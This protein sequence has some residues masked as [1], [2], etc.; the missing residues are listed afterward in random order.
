M[1]ERSRFD[2]EGFLGLNPIVSM[3]AWPAPVHDLLAVA[4]EINRTSMAII[5]VIPVTDGDARAIVAA[6][7][8]SRATTT[9]QS[10]LMLLTRGLEVDGLTLGRSLFETA[11]V[12]RGLSDDPGLVDTLTADYARHHIKIERE[13]KAQL[14][15]GGNTGDGGLGRRLMEAAAAQAQSQTGY[16][17]TSPSL[18]LQVLANKCGLEWLY[19]VVYRGLSGE[20][21]HPHFDSL[22]KHVNFDADGK[23]V[24]T[25]FR[26]LYGSLAN[27]ALIAILC[28]LVALDGA[29]RTFPDTALRGQLDAWLARVMGHVEKAAVEMAAGL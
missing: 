29:E 19:T 7:L 23:A 11:V 12:L 22:R 4:A 25:V 5:P 8:F 28:Q 14:G 21:S 2:A 3:D 10:A 9:F 18:N 17:T 6:T 13:L 16:A 20:A 15:A 24:G 27:S 26:P 1:T